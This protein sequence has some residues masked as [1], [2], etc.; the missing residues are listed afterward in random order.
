M[1][2]TTSQVSQSVRRVPGP[3]RYV[4]SFGSFSRRAAAETTAR[5]IRGK[6]YHAT[7]THVGGIFHVFSRPFQDRHSAEFWS[8]VY[9]EIGLNTH[10]LAVGRGAGN[11]TTEIDL[12]SIS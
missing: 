12:L 11:V 2:R 7:V 8:K 9:R 3:K 5:D 1:R 6:G 10:V 4:V